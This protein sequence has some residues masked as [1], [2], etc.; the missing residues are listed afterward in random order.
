MVGRPTIHASCTCLCLVFVSVRDNLAETL[1]I[2]GAVISVVL[3]RKSY[4]LR[5]HLRRARRLGF[6]F[7]ALIPSVYIFRV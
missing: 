4:R 2:G 6:R 5:R 3:I 1:V 7:A